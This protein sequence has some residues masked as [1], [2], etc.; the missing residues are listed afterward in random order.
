MNTWLKVIGFGNK[1]ITEAP[2]H[3]KYELDYVGFHR[4]GRPSIR[5][6]DHLFLYAAGGSKQVFAEAVATDDPRP[7]SPTDGD[8]PRWKLKIEYLTNL[9]VPFGVHID[10][11][12]TAR[13]DLTKSVM[14]ASHIKLHSDES[15]RASIKLNN[16]KSAT[17]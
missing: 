13:R 10:E 4:K 11:I 2:Y 1:P 6:G 16:L 14:R 12:I 5:M 8:G 7:N 3:G 15:E 9:R 17:R